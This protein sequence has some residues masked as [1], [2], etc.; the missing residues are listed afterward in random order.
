M[1]AQ[2]L[3]EGLRQS[4]QKAY[5]RFLKG[6]ELKPRAGQKLMIA[7]IARLLGNIRQ[8]DEGR[9]LGQDH[10]LVIEAGTGTG[11]TLGYLL[12][13]LPIAIARG[14]RLVI[15]TATVALQEQLLQRDLP[16]I[17]RFAELDFSFALAKGRG[18]YLCTA[19]LARLNDARGQT[20]DDNGTLSLF[21]NELL[22]RQSGDDDAQLDELMQ[23]FVSGRWDGDKDTLDQT[24]PESLWQRLTTDHQRCGNR[25]CPHFAHACPFFAARRDLENADV[26]VANHDLVLADLALGGGVVLPSPEDTF[27]VFDEGHHLP[28]KAIKH[29][30]SS[31]R[32]NG[33]LKWLKLLERSLPELMSALGES[34][35]IRRQ[36][37]QLTDPLTTIGRD[38][39][40]LNSQLYDIAQ[41]ERRS[42]GHAP[43]FRWPQGQVPE[44]LQQ[45][46]GH[47][48]TG[49]AQITR[50]LESMVSVL[51]EA[52]DPEKNTALDRAEAEAW[53]PMLS[54]LWTRSL[55][56]HELFSA[57]AHVEGPEDSPRARW[58]TLHINQTGDED[59][60]LASSPV[61][62]AG[63]LAYRLWSRCHGAVL[64]SATLTALGRFDRIRQRA[65]LPGDVA[66]RVVESPFDYPRLGVLEIPDLA[67][68]P[69]RGA[70]QHD[71]AIFRYLTERL[72]DQSA[73]LVLFSSRKQ[74]QAVYERLPSKWREA[75]LTQD[76]LSKGFLIARHR[77]RIDG[78][79]GSVIF[80][81]A[82]FA[83]G[84]DLP[85]RYLNHVII[86]RLPF[87]V[88]D[89]PVEATLAEWIEGRGG[90]PFMQ[91]TVPDASIRL[92]QACG[93]LIRTEQD[94]G[95]V[96]LL[97][98]RILTK[99][100]GQALLDALP[101]FRREI[102]SL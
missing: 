21:E 49:F 13:A 35:G 63:D 85:G 17:A 40:A 3:D 95:R 68:E 70:D 38:L 81:L 62:S 26:I 51:R 94:E 19:Q 6:R 34:D 10:I 86:T 76:G 14:K 44:T 23:A 46:A 71:E 92:V 22:S 32:V 45:F 2:G 36:L 96:T 11:K 98:R 91:I 88:P 37:N 99:R 33:A 41:F 89:D 42:D 43:Q 55:A 65:G 54:L 100:Y 69:G 57:Y 16:D 80:G 64:T 79:K 7:E 4:I 53:L 73:A 8:D 101:D 25:R 56:A 24:V 9:R 75:T 84:I 67:V 83:E 66:C 61:S 30:A 77:D 52:A 5:S 90:N 74:M 29:F 87:A 72:S 15:S 93:R 50:S 58:L 97:D 102:Q 60:E 20:E 47:L 78:G 27:Y 82:S 12:A 59:I 18:R 28:D 39:G 31:L 48:L 1:S